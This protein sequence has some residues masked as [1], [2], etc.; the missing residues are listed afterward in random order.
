MFLSTSHRKPKGILLLLPI[1]LFLGIFFLIPLIG[2]LIK[3]VTEPT[4][5]LGNFSELLATSTYIQ[6]LGNTFLVATLVTLFAILLGFPLAWCI[7]L[8]P[9]GWGRLLLNI[10][11]LSMWTSLLARTYSW[12]VL[13]QS[14]GVLNKVLMGIGIIDQPLEL[15][16]NLAG[17]I[18]GMTYIM[19]PFVVL[20]LQASMSTIDPMILQAASVCG[21]PARTVFFRVFIP[22]CKPGIFSGALMVFVMSLGYYVTPALLGGVSNMMLPEFIVQQIQNFLN[23]GI[24]SASA[25]ILIL[26]TLVMFYIYLKIQTDSPTSSNT[27][28]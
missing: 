1:L 13:L 22:L 24:A 7:T 8:F 4:L 15:V 27:G 21:A 25:S 11:L 17:V 5:G 12:L 2:L 23:W 10:V 14:S 6:V 16:H 26:V 19:I 3:S 28:D 9:K 20:P 18:I